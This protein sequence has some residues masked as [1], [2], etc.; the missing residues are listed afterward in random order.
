MFASD[1]VLIADT[2]HLTN[3]GINVPVRPW[4]GSSTSD[5]YILARNYT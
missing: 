2:T 1:R 5:F 4:K 3:V